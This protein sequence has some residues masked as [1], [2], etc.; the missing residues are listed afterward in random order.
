MTS[1]NNEKFQ[2]DDAFKFF[3]FLKENISNRNYIRYL[4]IEMKSIEIVEKIES[5]DLNNP[6]A[7]TM[8]K[9]GD[10]YYVKLSDLQDFIY[11]V[12]NNK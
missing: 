4:D 11:K 2:K 8:V 7:Q 1:D 5:Y 6:I 12:K 3:N 10:G 9:D